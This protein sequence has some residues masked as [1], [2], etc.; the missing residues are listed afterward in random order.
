LPA[1]DAGSASVVVPGCAMAAEPWDTLT[2][3]QLLALRGSVRRCSACGQL[4]PAD[5]RG[6]TCSPGCARYWQKVR[7]RERAARWRNSAK[8]ALARHLQVFSSARPP[9]MAWLHLLASAPAGSRLTLDLPDGS[10]IS[11]SRP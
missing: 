2:R 9:P 8:E 1:L 6:R 10:R 7:S 11:W 5:R 4:L 3:E